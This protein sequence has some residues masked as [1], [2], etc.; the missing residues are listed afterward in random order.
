[1]GEV[2]AL[3]RD[4]STLA[5]AA[6]GEGI[7]SPAGF[8]AGLARLVEHGPAR[9]PHLLFETRARQLLNGLSGDDAM[10]FLSG[11]LIGADVAAALDWHGPLD[12]LTLIGAPDLTALYRS[13]TMTHGGQCREIDGDSAVLAGLT[14]LSGRKNTDVHV[15]A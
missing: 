11:L 10:G 4:R 9:L 6:G 7:P 1:M 3:L 8:A 5:G 2:V 14:T 12:H 13:A 15:L